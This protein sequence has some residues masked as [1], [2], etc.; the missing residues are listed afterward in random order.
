MVPAPQLISVSIQG[1]GKKVRQI[2]EHLQTDRIKTNLHSK[3]A[4]RET[5]VDFRVDAKLVSLRSFCLSS[6][7]P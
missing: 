3:K 7:N 1:D 4:T 2:K 6:N 5:K